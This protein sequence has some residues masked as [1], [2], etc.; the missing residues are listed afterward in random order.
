[1]IGWLKGL[2]AEAVARM[3]GWDSDEGGLG[4]R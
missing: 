2:D 1:M 4:L 3:T